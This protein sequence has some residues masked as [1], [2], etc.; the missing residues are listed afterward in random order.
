VEKEWYLQTGD[1]IQLAIA[2]P[3]L[4]FIIPAGNKST[5]GTIGL[6]RRLTL[7][8]QQALRPYRTSIILLSLFLLLAIAGGA[9]YGIWQGGKI[10]ELTDDNAEMRAKTDTLI[11]NSAELQAQIEAYEQKLKEDS[12]AIANIPPPPPDVAKLIAAA[13]KDVYFVVTR[14]YIRHGTEIHSFPAS[15]GTGFMLNDGN[16]VTARHCV[17]PWLFDFSEDAVS[18]NVYATTYPDEFEAYSEVSAY[19]AKGLQF[20]LKSSDF[21][22]NRHKDIFIDVDV[23]E[24]N[25]PMRLRRAFPYIQKDGKQTGSETMLANDWAYAKV[26]HPSSLVADYKASTSLDTG[27][28]I[29]VLGFPVGLGVADGSSFIEPIYNKMSV[30]RNNLNSAGCI[31]TS[32]GVDHGNSGGP[33]FVMRDS[34]LV[35]VGIVSRGDPNTNQYNHIVPIQEIK[36]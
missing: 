7:F 14:S 15:S 13:K 1:E 23:D 30:S 35:V 18:V 17:E 16:F 2:G 4:G 9:G 12:I 36:H 24:N 28:E 34:R 26:S 31:M 3:K 33:A 21:K 19:S 25:R 20:T 6:S 27:E 11:S 32:Q 29:H 22:I 10:G 8:R 5:V